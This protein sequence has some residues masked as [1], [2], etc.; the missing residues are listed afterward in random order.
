MKKILLLFAIFFFATQIIPVKYIGY[1]CHYE[2]CDLNSSDD[3][4]KDECPIKCKE[5][6][7]SE[8]YL[9]NLIYNNI[10]INIVKICVNKLPV[11]YLKIPTDYIQNI[12]VP[13]P[14]C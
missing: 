10:S 2:V 11:Y 6:I 12:I 13:P 7:E 1:L 3:A 5:K 9:P 4:N 14:N 8:L